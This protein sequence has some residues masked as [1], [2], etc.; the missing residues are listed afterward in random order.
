MFGLSLFGQ[1]IEKRIPHQ[2][3]YGKVQHNK[4]LVLLK[5]LL[6]ISLDPYVYA[7]LLL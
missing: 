7:S 4:E 1:S 6:P 3:E 2:Q 5:R